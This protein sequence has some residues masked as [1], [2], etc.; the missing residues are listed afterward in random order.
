MANTLE[1]AQYVF[2]LQYSLRLTCAVHEDGLPPELLLVLIDPLGEVT[3][4]PRP[5]AQKSH[6]GG[7]L[8]AADA[9]L[10]QIPGI[11]N[12]HWPLSLLFP[13]LP[14]ALDRPL[15][16][17]WSPAIRSLP[18][19]SPS[20]KLHCGSIPITVALYPEPLPFSLDLLRPC[21]I[22]PFPA[23]LCTMALSRPLCSFW[24]PAGLYCDLAGRFLPYAVLLYPLTL[25]CAVTSTVTL[26]T[27]ALCTP[28]LSIG[29]SRDLALCTLIQVAV[30]FCTVTSCALV[31]L[32]VT[33]CT[34]AL[35]TVLGSTVLHGTEGRLG[36]LGLEEERVELVGGK[37][38]P[39]EVQ[40]CLAAPPKS[41][42]FL[43]DSIRGEREGGCVSDQHPA[44]RAP[45]VL[46]K[47]GLRDTTLASR[48]QGH[49][50]LQDSE[51]EWGSRE[52]RPEA[53]RPSRVE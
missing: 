9:R 16:S 17:S 15:S 42:Q 7:G 52:V 18:A 12:H 5:G 21:R 40:G 14:L 37:V 48:A 30:T 4:L 46:G 28:T 35:C 11:Q 43:Q 6:T 53:G 20:L 39:R 50:F 38:R 10:I 26:C 45:A 8:K 19:L 44:S 49:Q 31:L 33:L 25:C 22:I 51:R 2:S 29:V 27:D 36:G 32:T 3:E 41:H 13:L 34:L 24:L 47:K 1:V 23:A